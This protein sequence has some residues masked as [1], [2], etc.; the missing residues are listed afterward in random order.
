MYDY[1]K[2][3]EETKELSLTIGIEE[4]LNVINELEGKKNKIKQRVKQCREK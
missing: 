4:K 1:K 2:I 3:E